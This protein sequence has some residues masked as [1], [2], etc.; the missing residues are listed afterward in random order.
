ML[1]FEIVCEIDV[2]E[3]PLAPVIPLPWLTDHPKVV[4]LTP[5]E[6]VIEV[7]LPVQIDELAGVTVTAGEGLITTETV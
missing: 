1:L 6:R 7:V 2:P 3:E 5:L 4:P